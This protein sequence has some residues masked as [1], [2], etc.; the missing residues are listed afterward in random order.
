MN[1][2]AS[3]NFTVVEDETLNISEANRRDCVRF[4]DQFAEAW[5]SLYMPLASGPQLGVPALDRIYSM[6]DSDLMTKLEFEVTVG[7]INMQTLAPYTQQIELYISPRLLKNNRVFMRELYKHRVELPNLTVSCYKS[8]NPNAGILSQMIIEF[9]PDVSGENAGDSKSEPGSF[10]QLSYSDFGYYK[11]DGLDETDGARRVNLNVMLAINPAIA[12]YVMEQKPV[13]FVLQDGKESTRDVWV[14]K[15]NNVL[16]AFL[17]A[18]VGEYNMLNRIGYIEYVRG[19]SDEAKSVELHEFGDIRKDLEFIESQN[20]RLSACD[21]CSRTS[22]QAKLF[23]CSC[24]KARYCS[25]KCQRALWRS[26]SKL[27][28]ELIKRRD[29]L[30]SVAADAAD[31]AANA[32]LAVK[33]VPNVSSG[34]GSATVV[35]IA[36]IA[37]RIKALASCAT[38]RADLVQ[39][40]ELAESMLADISEM[41]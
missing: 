38:S 37:R 6:L 5:N 26:H 14:P 31:I 11:L 27:H 41:Q 3:V 33:C 15:S 7:Q 25:I 13:T 16:T 32:V 17:L 36:A 20:G 21:Y 19:D 34:P 28:H 1:N 23:T 22:G 2:I 10:L 29:V 8:W 4:W 40:T 39:L 35:N 30:A 24:H 18:M 9:D 12:D